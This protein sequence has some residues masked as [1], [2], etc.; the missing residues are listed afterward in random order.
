MTIPT[1]GIVLMLASSVIGSV[2]LLKELKHRGSA[3][4]KLLK[5]P[6]YNYDTRCDDCQDKRRRERDPSLCNDRA[7]WLS[8][9]GSASSAGCAGWTRP[10]KG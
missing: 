8:G 7:T 2:L 1:W 5:C 9:P 10:W 4:V 6:C 3:T